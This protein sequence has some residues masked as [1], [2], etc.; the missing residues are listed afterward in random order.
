MPCSFAR[1]AFVLPALAVFAGRDGLFRADL[2]LDSGWWQ[3]SRGILATEEARVFGRD[4]IDR[5]ARFAALYN[6]ANSIIVAFS[7]RTRSGLNGDN[8]LAG[9]DS[10]N[11]RGSHTSRYVVVAAGSPRGERSGC[12]KTSARLAATTV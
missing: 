6:G 9:A 4:C 5:T 2:M 3:F 1:L 8:C 7:L 12:V 11:G 10:F